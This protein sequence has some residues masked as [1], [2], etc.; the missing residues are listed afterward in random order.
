MSDSFS[1]IHY[2][3]VGAR[4]TTSMTCVRCGIPVNV[5]FSLL[6]SCIKDRIKL[7]DTDY[8]INGALTGWSKL[9]Y[10]YDYMVFP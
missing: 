1:F 9:P 3:F 8:Q 10:D 6:R 2:V 5:E 7:G 4:A